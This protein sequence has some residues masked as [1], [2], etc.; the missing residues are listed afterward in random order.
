VD[1]AA[2]RVVDVTVTSGSLGNVFLEGCVFSGLFDLQFA[3]PAG[4]RL[5]LTHRYV[6]VTIGYPKTP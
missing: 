1:S 6:F 5:T 2:G 4:G 3:P